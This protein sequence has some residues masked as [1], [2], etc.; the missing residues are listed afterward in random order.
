MSRNDHREPLIEVSIETD[1]HLP[2]ELSS[3]NA[4]KRIFK[5]MRFAAARQI[6]AIVESEGEHHAAVFAG[7]GGASADGTHA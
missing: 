1:R 7:T 6:V 3:S 2:C 4:M 5:R